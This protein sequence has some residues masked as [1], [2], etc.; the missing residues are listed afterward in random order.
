M[1]Y[2]IVG[3]LLVVLAA[4]AWYLYD[5]AAPTVE[6]TVVPGPTLPLQEREP[7]PEVTAPEV[8]E[9]AIAEPLPE[10]EPLAGEPALPALAESDD[11]ALRSLSEVVDGTT[12]VERY[13]VEEDVIA[14]IVATV[15]A[16]DGKQVPE[17]IQAVQGP[18][19]AFEATPDDQPDEVILND[20]GD[21]VPQF[22]LNP[23]NYRRYTPYVA[24]L[25]S[26]NAD[27]LARAY[28]AYQPL[29]EEAF[30][31]LGY[32]DSD[33]EERLLKVIDDALAAP[34][35]ER[36]LQLIKPEAYFLFADEDLEAL[37]AAQKVMLRMGPDN[38]ARVKAKLAEIRAALAADE[39]G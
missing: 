14:R 27:G 5:T 3:T 20:L 7:P 24:M 8:T 2:W 37:N 13:V 18:G 28:R 29:F 36:P 22:Q 12:P 25:E 32:P 35:P 17:A 38:A 9:P 26:V 10:S 6:E 34:E 21:P 1:K 39:S 4:V 11:E 19:G 16:L 31:Q 30:D 33:F 23:A 15:D